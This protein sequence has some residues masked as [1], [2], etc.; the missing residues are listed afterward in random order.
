MN[1]SVNTD[2]TA[3]PQP[4]KSGY[5]KILVA[6]DYLDSTPDIFNQAL[7]L[8]ELNRAELMI[9]HSVQSEISN[10]PEIGLYPG[11]AVYGGFYSMVEYEEKLIQEA[12]EE[13]LAWLNSFVRLAHERGINAQ[14]DYIIGEAGKN[15]TDMAQSWGADLIVLGRRG[16]RGLSELLLGSVSNY[17]IHHASCSVLVVQ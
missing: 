13:L 2:I 8:A 3:S 11:M 16:R 9:F 1:T 4:S 15:I 10:R 6:V 7:N 14:S 17:V 12:T 5:K